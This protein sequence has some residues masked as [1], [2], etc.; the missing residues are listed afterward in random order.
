[1]REIRGD[2][3]GQASA[4]PIHCR[5]TGGVGLHLKVLGGRAAR[6]N[7]RRTRRGPISSCVSSLG[8]SKTHAHAGRRFTPERTV[9]RWLYC[10][11]SAKKAPGVLRLWV[12]E[13]QRKQKKAGSGAGLFALSSLAARFIAATN[14]PRG[15]RKS[16]H[17]RIGF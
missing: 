12:E 10:F 1:M 13:L 11:H 2:L 5:L 7:S 3:R 9:S 4:A 8:L 14:N 6:S 15:I 16:P 17:L